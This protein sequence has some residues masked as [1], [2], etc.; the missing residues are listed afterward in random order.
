MGSKKCVIVLS[1]WF[2]LLSAVLLHAF[3]EVER[4]KTSSAVWLIEKYQNV[5]SQSKVN[6]CSSYPSCSEY[7]RRAY[8]T[9]PFWKAT[10]LTSDRLNRCGHDSDKY[11]ML[12]VEG[13]KKRYDPLTGDTSDY[14]SLKESIR[15]IAPIHPVD[16]IL[17]AQKPNLSEEE[18]LLDFARYLHARGEL[19]LALIEY[20]RFLRRYPLSHLASSARVSVMYLYYDDKRYREAITWAEEAISQGDIND[21][22]LAEIN[23]WLGA[24]YL[25][26]D[27]PIRAR[28]NFNSLL[29]ASSTQF[30]IKA[31]LLEGYS[32]AQEEQWPAAIKTF[33]EY[34]KNFNDE[35][36][37]TTLA[38]CCEKALSKYKRSPAL[39]GFLGVFPG[40][41]YLYAGYPQT[42]ISAFLIDAL[43]LTASYKAFDNGNT[44]LGAL[45]GIIG[46]GWYSGSIYG[47]VSAA[48]R[49]NAEFLRK[50][51]LQLNLGFRF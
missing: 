28:E 33:R 5:I 12:W 7:G 9:Y 11:E 14:S 47:S 35:M 51:L 42:A 21:A 40:L 26:L 2:L 19:D 6:S 34:G 36:H 24:A 38:G 41:G 27:N 8:G 4:L 3:D 46:I 44:P 39:A 32:Y 45:L 17:K 31:K 1:L 30:S 37:A 20:F 22:H 49:R 50:T 10:L 15:E 18:S 43:L 29:L 48:D 13:D 23:F 16:V 25:R